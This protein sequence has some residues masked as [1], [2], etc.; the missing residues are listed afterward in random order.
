M[1]AGLEEPFERGGI[2]PARKRKAGQC[3]QLGIGLKFGRRKRVSH[4]RALVN[5]EENN[6]WS[7]GLSPAESVSEVQC[8]EFLPNESRQAK[9][10]GDHYET[11]PNQAQPVKLASAGFPKLDSWQ[12]R[13]Q[14]ELN[15]RQFQSG[16]ERKLFVQKAHREV[17]PPNS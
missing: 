3:R 4:E 11:S 7:N 13:F 1:C 12:I 8:G 17:C 5:G 2:D 16:S 9:L 10:P 14:P 6:F 15:F